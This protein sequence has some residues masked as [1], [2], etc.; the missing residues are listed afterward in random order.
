M[1][2]GLADN[3]SMRRRFLLGFAVVAA[4]AIGSVGLA[5]VVHERERDNFEQVQ[6]SEAKR[7]ARQAE[8]LAALSVGQLAS[9]AAFYQAVD[10]LSEDKFDVMADSLLDTGAL[11]ATGFVVEVPASQRARFER[12]R[13]Y[14]IVERTGLGFRPAGSRSNHY[15]LVL[16][17]S[18]SGLEPPLGYDLGAD[19]RR[20]THLLRARDQGGAAAT[21]VMHL[22]IGG[23]GINVF[24]PVYRNGAPT[25]SAAQGRG[26]L[27]GFAVGAFHVADLAGAASAALDGDVDVQLVEGNRSVAGPSLDRDESATAQLRIADRTWLLVVH[28]PSRPGVGLPVLI[29]IV[30]ISLAALLAALVLVWSR[31]ERMQELKRQ[32]G[33][34]PLTGLKNRRRFEEDLR[35][36]LARSRREQTVGAV[37]MLDFDNFKQV[38]DTLG[39][40]IGDRTIAEIAAVLNGR[41]RS[42]DVV[43]RL[44]GDEFAIVLPRCDLDEAEE[45]AEAIALAIRLHTL[46]GEAAPPLTASIGIATFGPHSGGYDAVLSAADNAMYEAKRAGRDSVRVSAGA[47]TRLVP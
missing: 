1:G 44:G 8:A 11:S 18:T 32:A 21:S 3:R 36:E 45:I 7:S 26:A 34:D 13:G 37:M 31:N 46:P 29:A 4:I 17:A 42:T 16:A 15:P 28:D 47:T 19:G 38:N 9:A 27:V 39:H 6:Q 2:P 25:A 35:R 24:H 33:Q 10:R 30:G 22:P 20:S 23:T 43:A 40:P 5:L 14:R 41:M 12:E